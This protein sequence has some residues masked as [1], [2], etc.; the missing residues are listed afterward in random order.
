[1]IGLLASVAIASGAAGGLL[2]PVQDGDLMAFLSGGALSVTLAEHDACVFAPDGAVRAHDAMTETCRD[3]LAPCRSRLDLAPGTVP[4]DM[5]MRMFLTRCLREDSGRYH[6][7]FQRHV[8]EVMEALRTGRLAGP[9]E[10]TVARLVHDPRAAAAEA[11]RGCRA[12]SAAED[13]VAALDCDRD[14][15]REALLRARSAMREELR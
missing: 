12:G 15:R 11:N 13:E 3:D 9:R 14:T 4:R 2:R 5:G 7:L 1:M 6:V 10:V 8:A